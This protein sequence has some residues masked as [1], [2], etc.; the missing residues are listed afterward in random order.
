MLELIEEDVERALRTV[1]EFLR[2][3]G[4]RFIT[5]SPSTH[6]RVNH[7][8]ENAM[9]S[10][11]AGVFGW[12]RPFSADVLGTELFDLLARAGALVR[13]G[14]QFRSTIR[15]SSLGE[16]LFVHSAYPTG[17]ADSVFFGPDTYRFA[18]A[19]QSWQRLGRSGDL[20]RV[21]D[22]GCGAGPGGILVAGRAP[23]AEVVLVDINDAALR[24]ARINA[25]L[26]GTRNIAFRLSDVLRDVEGDFDLIVSNPPYLNDPLRR[27]YR[28]GGGALGEGLSE[29]I[30]GAAL[31]RLTPGGTLLLYTGVAIVK[32]LDP[33]RQHVAER[34]GG[35]D[36]DW[37]YA[38]MDPDVFGDELDTATYGEADR[39]AAVVLTVT[40]K[41]GKDAGA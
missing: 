34:L 31:K 6:A 13:E 37:S 5:V 36:V 27:A 3:R 39:I 30:L 9:A 32:G 28:H 12:S 15:V 16:E 33:F 23:S 20:R 1:V 26:A 7:R 25:V 11:L 8:R 21:A 10:D 2:A 40:R 24:F 41:G 38:E 22:I 17:S 14:D 29:L 19:I 35:R 4:Y 18:N